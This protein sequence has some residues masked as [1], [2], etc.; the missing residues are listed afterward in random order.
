LLELLGDPVGDLSRAELGL[1]PERER[2]VVEYGHRV[3]QRAAL[4]HHAI[5][6]ADPVEGRAP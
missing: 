5:P 1:L 2:D 4:E 3:E 6:L